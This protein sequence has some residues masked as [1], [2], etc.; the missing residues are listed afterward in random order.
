MKLLLVV[1]SLLFL[2]ACERTKYDEL[3]NKCWVMGGRV[4]T[5]KNNE[6]E[7]YRKTVFRRTPKLLFVEK[8]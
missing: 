8:Y 1:L 6:I 5:S 2:M 7:C 3:V 4:H